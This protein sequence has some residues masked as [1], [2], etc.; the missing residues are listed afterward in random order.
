MFAGRDRQTQSLF[1]RR[2]NAAERGVEVGPK[3]ANGDDDRDRDTGRDQAVFD[4]GR[5][6]FV[7]EKSS[8]SSTDTHFRTPTNCPGF[9]APRLQP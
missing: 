4:R 5:G 6:A 9:V 2:R 7:A 8:H 3:R 1:D